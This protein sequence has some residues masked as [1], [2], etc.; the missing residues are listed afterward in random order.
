MKK[1]ISIGIVLTLVLTAVA[2]I[3]A[4]PTVADEPIYKLYAGQ[5]IL[6][7]HVEVSNDADNLY[8]KYVIDAVNCVDWCITETHLQIFTDDDPFTGIVLKNSNPPPGQ[9]DYI[10]EHDCVYEYEYTIPLNPSWGLDDIYIAAHAKIKSLESIDYVE[11]VTN[12]GFET[13]LVEGVTG[14]MIVLDEALLNGWTTA[15]NVP[16]TF[17]DPEGLELQKG[18]FGLTAY[19]GLQWAEL[20]AYYPVILT[21]TVDACESGEYILS[22][23]YAPRPSV[24]D[25]QLN[26][27]FGDYEADHSGS[28]VG[29]TDWTHV[30]EMVTGPTECT[31]DLVFTETGPDDQLGMYLDDVSLKC[32]VYNYIYESAW[33]ATDVGVKD[34]P[35]KN[36]ATYFTYNVQGWVLVDTINVYANTGV[37]VSSVAFENGEE[38]KIVASGTAFAG[39]TIDFDAKYSLTNRISGDTWTDCVSGYES[40]GPTLLDLEVNGEFVDWGVYNPGHV[41]TIYLT[42]T[43]TPPSFELVVYDIYYPNNNGFI[44]VEIYQWI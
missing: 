28:G 36:W 15:P 41:Y 10:M 22:Y 20:D 19:E 42:G 30:Q 4:F 3:I 35:G 34:F 25:N 33:A 24:P 14:W 17:G 27:V 7:G 43:G 44:T 38:Y 13:P 1:T 26:V 21:Q 16:D 40:Y 31:A 6:V 8:V 11:L 5:D 23:A 12:G 2:G 32:V 37:P 39:D 29:G 18:L 9:F